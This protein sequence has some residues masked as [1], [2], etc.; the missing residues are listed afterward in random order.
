MCDKAL[1][2]KKIF[3]LLHM[4]FTLSYFA[5]TQT[6]KHEFMYIFM[7]AHCTRSL[8]IIWSMLCSAKHSIANALA[9]ALANTVLNFDFGI[10]QIV[11]IFHFNFPEC[12][13]YIWFDKL[14]GF[15]FVSVIQSVFLYK[16]KVYSTTYINK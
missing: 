11:Y 15:L 6:Y 2:F 7:C 16:Y 10:Y 5:R 4:L 13:I 1:A 14:F 9:I 8:T 12:I 3:K